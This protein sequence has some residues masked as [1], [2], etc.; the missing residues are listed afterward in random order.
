MI[1]RLSVSSFE[2]TP[3]RIL[4]KGSEELSDDF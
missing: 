2:R 1:W 3:A 4:A